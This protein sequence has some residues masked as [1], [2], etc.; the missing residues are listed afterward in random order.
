MA[1]S[2]NQVVLEK[3]EQLSHETRTILLFSYRYFFTSPLYVFHQGGRSFQELYKLFCM[4][5][6]VSHSQDKTKKYMHYVCPLSDEDHKCTLTFAFFPSTNFQQSTQYLA[7]ILDLIRGLTLVLLSK[8]VWDRSCS[9]G[10][11]S[12]FEGSVCQT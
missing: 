7:Q 8:C 1:F 5:V 9:R 2:R 10:K 6:S 12:K 3:I 11:G 4:K